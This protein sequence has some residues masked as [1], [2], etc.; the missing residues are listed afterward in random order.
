MRE[1]ESKT[2]CKYDLNY[3]KTHTPK[4]LKINIPKC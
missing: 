1:E 3:V 4:R 2:N